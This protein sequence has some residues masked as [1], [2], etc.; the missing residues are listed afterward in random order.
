MCLVTFQ[1]LGCV[2]CWFSASKA[3][4]LGGVEW[5]DNKFRT[6]HQVVEK[7]IHF[8]PPCHCNS[9]VSRWNCWPNPIR[10]K[11]LWGKGWNQ[12]RRDDPA[13]CQF[14]LVW[15]IALWKNSPPKKNHPAKKIP[16]VLE[17]L[18]TFVASTKTLRGIS[19]Q[20]SFHQLFGIL[21]DFFCRKDIPPRNATNTENTN[22]HRHCS[23][24]TA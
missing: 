7:S 3:F 5:I 11:R 13:N 22:K 14:D 10:L 2:F 24:Y 1:F 6:Q 12:S 18:I 17:F 15:F 23:Q 4:F 9:I 19:M 8:Y 21:P 20:Q 16:A